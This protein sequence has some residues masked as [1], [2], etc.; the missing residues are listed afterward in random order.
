MS[1]NSADLGPLDFII[2][3]AGAAVTRSV[4]KRKILRD[5]ERGE[6]DE[7]V[8]AA[9]AVFAHQSMHK[10]TDG[11]IGLGGISGVNSAIKELDRR[12]AAAASA[13][14]ARAGSIPVY[15]APVNDNSEAWRLNT[16]EGQKYGL[17]P[18]D[19]D[20]REEYLSALNELMSFKSGLEE[21]NQPSSDIEATLPDV[22]N[23]HVYCKVSLLNNGKN[24]YYLA[25]EINVSVGDTVKVPDGERE[26]TGIVLSVEQHSPAT[27]PYNLENLTQIISLV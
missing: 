12:K 6:G 1:K 5:Y 17:D 25:D 16:E 27:A 19:F 24:R 15:S 21:S 2:D 18:N 7:S 13:R 14:R 22:G 3:L 4:A 8:I 23:V 26:T 9:T 11:M 20:T 10:G